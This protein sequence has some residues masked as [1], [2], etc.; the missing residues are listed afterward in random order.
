M[1]EA[2]HTTPSA[3]RTS[4]SR[5]SLSSSR[6][7]S[8]TDVRRRISITAVRSA[9]PSVARLLDACSLTTS[10]RPFTM[11]D[12]TSAAGTPAGIAPTAS[13]SAWSGAEP[14]TQT[15]P[16]QSLSTFTVIIAPLSARARPSSAQFSRETEAR[17]D[18]V[19]GQ[20]KAPAGSGAGSPRNNRPCQGGF[21]PR[22][23]AFCETIR[24]VNPQPG[25]KLAA[26][27]KP[28]ESGRQRPHLLAATARGRVLH[29]RR[30]APL[31][32]QCTCGG[33]YTS[34]MTKPLTDHTNAR[35]SSLNTDKPHDK[36]SKSVQKDFEHLCAISTT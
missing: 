15:S 11:S 31:P 32:T 13:S 36:I 18:V 34:G 6:R 28:H 26:H 5:P 3:A 16:F 4:S 35:N 10:L 1:A 9:M 8:P 23:A 24:R 17:P 30:T 25:E 22:G 2:A 29:A 33:R 27:D 20:S 12:S 14:S 7:I 19:P 21:A